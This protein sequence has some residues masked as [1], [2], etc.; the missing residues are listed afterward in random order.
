[1]NVNNISIFEYTISIHVDKKG[2]SK[3][4]AFLDELISNHT[5][6]IGETITNHPVDLQPLGKYIG[7]I[8][9]I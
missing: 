1:M 3:C 9:W 5:S 2:Q 7:D 8:R 4:Q 6:M